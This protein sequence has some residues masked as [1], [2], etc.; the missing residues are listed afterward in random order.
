MP[1]AP[2]TG[3]DLHIDQPLSNVVVGRRPDGFIADQLLPITNVSKRSDIFYK[4]DH[5]ESRRYE[6]GLTNRAPA[7]RS[8]KVHFTVT[9]D[10]YYAENYALG[11]SLTQE[12]AANADEVLDWANTQILFLD[13]M[14][15]FDYERRVADLARAATS[16]HTT[17]NVATAWSNR[18]GSRPYDDLV[19]KIESYRQVAGVK[20][21]LII[22][23]EAIMV[24]LRANDQFRDLLHGDSGGL[25]TEQQ[26]G[27][28]IGIPR[29]L[30]PMSQINTAG[31]T[32][33]IN[34]SGSL[35]DVW[36]DEVILANVNLLSGRFTD[37]W[38]NA[39]RWTNPQFGVPFAVKRFP[40]D[41]ET[42]EWRMEIDYYQVEKIVSSD[43][44]WKVNSLV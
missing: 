20:P 33:T 6:A 17:T 39:F 38:M 29:V 13:D 42:K 8:N 24:N 19:D 9:S 27:G 35:A 7:T 36:G 2:S 21:N 22:I 3:R 25:V 37:T 1:S 14:V 16:V 26:I 32:E 12:D 5:M 34:G 15:K 28:L 4:Y 31:E 41:A 11:T 44:A 10:T 43:L 40:F 18:T 23:P 30:V